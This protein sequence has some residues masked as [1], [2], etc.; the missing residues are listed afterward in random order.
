MRAYFICSAQVTFSF[1]TL[2]V[3]IHKGRLWTSFNL[4]LNIFV[5][6]FLSLVIL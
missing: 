5:F 2:F 6:L 3:V 4:G 1:V